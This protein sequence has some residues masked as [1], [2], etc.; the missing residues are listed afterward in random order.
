VLP[1]CWDKGLGRRLGLESRRKLVQQGSTE[2]SLWVL[3]KNLKAIRCYRAA[4]FAPE[5]SSRKCFEIGGAQVP[6]IRYLQPVM[7]GL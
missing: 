5:E 4:G 2:I 3:E 6:E 1:G 7:S